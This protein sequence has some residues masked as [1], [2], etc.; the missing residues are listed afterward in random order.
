MKKIVPD[1]PSALCIR[2][3]L[4]HENALQLAQQHL[5]RAISNANEAAEDAPTKQRWLI[6]DAVLQM[7]ITRALLKVSVA[8][9]SVVV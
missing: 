5:E 7:E 4:S 6:H 8:T 1:P 9:L 2:A 3:G